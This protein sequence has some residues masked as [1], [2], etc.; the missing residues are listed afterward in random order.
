MEGGIRSK[1]TSEEVSNDTSDTVNS[2]DIKSIINAHEILELGTV[3]ASSGADNTE[4]NSGPSRDETRSRS[5]GDETRNDTRAETDGGPLLFESV[6]EETPGNTSN[7][8][9]QVGDNTGHDG[10]EV[11]TQSRTSVES[12]PS[13]PEKHSTD[14]NMGD[15]VRTVVEFV[16]TVATTLAEHQGVSESGGTGGNVHGSTTGEVKTSELEYP[17][18]WV[19][20]P[21][22]NRI[23]DDG[24][25]DKHEDDARKH[26]TTLGNSA[27]SKSNTDGLL[28]QPLY[29][30]V[31]QML[32]T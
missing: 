16:R 12:E 23:V 1:E 19:P 3:V 20:G 25:P 17:T 15:I 6:V 9:C 18:R 28:A 8:S 32:L 10:A 31:K 30:N 13:D 4:D 27:N 2:I 24:G 14:D 22:G 11:S 7:R 5:D 21:A 29:P 26:A